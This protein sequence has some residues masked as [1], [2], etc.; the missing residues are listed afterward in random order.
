MIILEQK[1][2]S[3]LGLKRSELNCLQSGHTILGSAS[4]DSYVI[5][6]ATTNHET[7]LK[8]T[9]VEFPS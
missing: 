9:T 6:T 4:A 7:I 8:L 5:L 2:C 1:L 3:A